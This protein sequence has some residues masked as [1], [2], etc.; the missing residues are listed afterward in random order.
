MYKRRSIEHTASTE[1][2]IALL[3]EIQ[4]MSMPQFPDC[5]D[6]NAESVVEIECKILD[7]KENYSVAWNTNLTNT[8]I[9]PGKHISLPFLLSQ[10]KHTQREQCDGKIHIYSTVYGFY[11]LDD[12]Q[13]QITAFSR[14]PGEFFILQSKGNHILWSEN[15]DRECHVY[16]HEHQSRKEQN[17]ISEC[18]DSH[19]LW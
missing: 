13:F 10:C 4:A 6:V 18:A 15:R 7:D 2:D 8:K 19:H 1:L 16:I 5:R 9:G 17:Q 11:T 12:K 3:P 14:T